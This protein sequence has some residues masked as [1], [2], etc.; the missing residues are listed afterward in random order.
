MKLEMLNSL[1]D[2]EIAYNLLKSSSKEGK[3]PIDS[4]YEQLKT[5]IAVLDKTSDEYNILEK[6]V[7]QTHASTHT[8]YTLEIQQV[9]KM[10]LNSTKSNYKYLSHITQY[11]TVIVLIISF[12]DLQDFST[13]GKEAI[14]AISETSE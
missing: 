10:H 6:Y 14:Q 5:E 8:L 4:H 3:D 12:V 9:L 7:K 1:L 13:R 11:H 2:I